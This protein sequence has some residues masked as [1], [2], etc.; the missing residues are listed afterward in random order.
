MAPT[1]R[2]VV[3]TPAAP[4]PI[5]DIGFD[6][7]SRQPVGIGELDRVLGGGFV[8]GSVTLVGG[9]P[10]AGKSTLLLQAADALADVAGT[11]VY[12]SAEESPEQIRGRAGRLGTL[13]P[14]LQLACHTDVTAIVSILDDHRPAACVVDSIQ[15][16]EHPDVAGVAGGV[17]QVRE[18]ASVLARTAKRLGITVVLVGHVTKDGQLAG[19]RTLEHLVDTVVEF[20]GD[21]HHALRLL[22]AVKNRFGPVGEVGCFEMTADGL[23]SVGDAG[24]L[25][26][27]EAAPDSTGVAT[28]LVLEGRRPLACEVQALVAPT[29]LANPRRIT[30]GLD[31]A[32]LAV[33]TAVLQQRVGIGLLD[34][35]IYAASVGGLRITEPAA[36][37]A[38]A[39]AVAS[40]A[41]DRPLPLG[42]VALGEVGLA[43]EIRQVARMSDRLAEASRLGF[44]SA[45][46]P[47]AYDGA[48]GGMSLYRVRDLHEALRAAGL[49]SSGRRDATADRPVDAARM[50]AAA[51]PG[52]AEAR[53]GAAAEPGSRARVSVSEPEG[54]HRPEA[55]M[56]AAAE[57]GSAEARMGAAA[58]PGSAEARK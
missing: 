54:G 51:E 40:G 56:G 43:G 19:P 48:D 4:V 24:R 14:R 31:G 30:S 6:D 34:R 41:I 52:S 22:R 32:R 7:L 38:L 49:H 25:F 39:L 46:V 29:T 23:R 1:R 12:C 36:D 17:A 42:V 5:A 58:E 33:L 50:G 9:E 20:D 8:T 3:T 13:H 35:D 15:T 37:L 11:V 57:P 27:G 53:M 10:G 44:G 16:V 55:R 26:V 47:A 28:T 18:C 2:P 45:L 21:R